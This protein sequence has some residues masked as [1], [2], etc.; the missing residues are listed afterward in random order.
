MHNY[1]IIVEDNN[2]RYWGMRIKNRNP[3]P[4]KN[5][6]ILIKL[7]K[8]KLEKYRLWDERITNFLNKRF[9]KRFYY[10]I[11]GYNKYTNLFRL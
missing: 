1:S 3:H 9:K 11:N 10:I 2:G 4:S 7:I 5:L 6:M 8:K